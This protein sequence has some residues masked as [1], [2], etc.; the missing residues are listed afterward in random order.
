MAASAASRE[1]YP[2]LIGLSFVPDVKSGML[3]PALHPK[4][5]DFWGKQSFPITQL[6]IRSKMH[7][8]IPNIL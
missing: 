1:E 7:F 4:S 3:I 2:V 6:T 5:M 8:L